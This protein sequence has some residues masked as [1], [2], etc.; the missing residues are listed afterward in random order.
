MMKHL[1]IG[2][3][4]LLS[5]G[6]AWANTCASINDLSGLD[7]ATKQKMVVECEQAK[8]AAAQN[9]TPAV[10]GLGDTLTDPEALSQWGRVAN[11][12]AKALGVAAKEMGI[13]ADE[14]L[15]TGAGKL[16]A[17]LIV[18]HVAGQELIG[19][20]VGLPMLIVI[21]WK[22]LRLMYRVNLKEVEYKDERTWTGKRI[23]AKEHYD[24]HDDA[25]NWYLFVLLLALIIGTW[26]ILGLMV[27]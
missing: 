9:A 11:E 16:T 14:F 5:A 15:G 12:F 8:L 4:L 27:F 19:I 23:V 1:V 22:L 2:V 26:M 17:A 7:A 13:A 20:L 3:V 10:P 6:G 24:R 21:W 25:K 18:W